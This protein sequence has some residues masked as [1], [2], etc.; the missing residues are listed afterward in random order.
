MSL[1]PSRK[2]K[3]FAAVLVLSGG[4]LFSL[5]APKP[6]QALYSTSTYQKL[7]SEVLTA[8]EWNNLF[9]DFV[10]TWLPVSL[11]GP[12]GIATPAPTSGL[13]VNGPILATGNVGIGATAPT[14]KLEIIP[15]AGSYALLAGSYRIG[16]VALPIVS[17][18]AATKG[19]VDSLLGAGS[20]P[21]A[22]LGQTLRYDGAAWISDSSLFNNATNI[23]IG[24]TAPTA[25]LE[26][27]PSAGNYALLAGNYKIG[28]VALPTVDADAATKGY[29][30]SFV[31]SSI[32]TAT[33]SIATLWGG[34]TGANIWSLN[35]GNVGIGT[36]A[37]SK[38]LEI[39]GTG[40]S[41]NLQLYDTDI[42]GAAW[43]KTQF[44]Q[45]SGVLYVK[46]V[47]ADN[48]GTGSIADFGPAS[49]IN[50]YRDV[51]I[52][53][54]VLQVT[55]TGNSYFTG[56]VGIGTTNLTA[57]LN[58][59]GDVKFEK[60]GSNLSLY[61]ANT[62]TGGG[63]FR[64]IVGQTG[65]SMAGGLG[66]YDNTAGA[67][68]LGLDSTGNLGIAKTNPAATLD[69]VGSI[70][71]TGTV[72]G[73]GLCIGGDCKV[74]WSSIG[75]AS[76][77]WSQN[78]NEV[79]KTNTAGNVG[80]G[81]TNPLVKLEVGGAIKVGTSSDTCGATNVGSV[82]YNA[83]Q[84]SM[85]YCDGTDWKEI[86]GAPLGT[87]AAFNGAC[88]SG[89]EELTEL[90]GRTIIGVGQGTGLTNRTLGETGGEETHILSID[91]MPSHSH[92]VNSN[93]SSPPPTYRNTPVGNLPA[94]SSQGNI[95]GPNTPPS[96]SL[97]GS[98]MIN[99]TG[100]ST[101]F[102]NM[103]PFIALRYCRKLTTSGGDPVPTVT[104]LSDLG[105]V[106][107]AAPVNGSTFA[108]SSSVGKWGANNNLVVDGNGNVG[109]GRTNPNA[110][111]YVSGDA[112]INSTL[113]TPSLWV[114]T[115]GTG[116]LLSLNKNGARIAGFD[117]SGNMTTN[118]T[119][120]ASGLNNSSFAGNVGIAKTSPATTVDVVG[121]INSTGT[122]NGTGLCI[123]GDCKVSWSAVG[124]AS[125]GWNRIS[126]YI[127][128]ATL[129]DNV[130]IGVTNPP[131]KLVVSQD[132]TPATNWNSAQF[133]ISGS[134]LNQKLAL[135]YDT[136]ANV[137]IIQAG[138]AGTYEP[139]AI[140]PNGGNVGIGTTA[141]NRLLSVQGV[142]GIND[143]GGV[144]RFVVSPTSGG[145]DLHIKDSAGASTVRFDTRAGGLSYVNTGNF[146]VGTASPQT[147][148]NVLG[149]T[150]GE[151]FRLSSPRSYTTGNGPMMVFSELVNG[152]QVA[153]LKGSF[154]VDGNGNYGK[155]Q[156]YTRTSD[157]LGIEEKMVINHNGNV[158]IS[159]S[160]PA[161]T[162]DVV[163]GINSTGTLNGTGLCI[164]GDCKVSWAA[165][166]AASS[167]W[168]QNGNEVYKTSISGN[169]GIGTTAPGKALEVNTDVSNGG[170][171]L[172]GANYPTFT[173]Q[174]TTNNYNV[175]IIQGD[176]DTYFEESSG[177]NSL[178]FRFNGD[179]KMTLLNSGNV[180][181]GLTNPT[182]KLEVA[183]NIKKQNKTWGSKSVQVTSSWTTVLSITMNA[184]TSATVDIN[185]GGSDWSSH[186]AQNY[187]AQ[188]V[189]RNG[190]GAYGDPGSVISE[191]NDTGTTND[192]FQSQIVNAGSGVF[193]IQIK[194]NDGGDGFAGSVSPPALPLEY[195]IDGNYTAVN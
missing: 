44:Y 15:S 107:I 9:R 17:A 146:G 14:A 29:V 78:G 135:G 115:T 43:G 56:N 144:E 113:N 192:Y 3:I 131:A 89:W 54:K 137:G 50:L 120:I 172:K 162:L 73:T 83:T 77:G 188:Y 84:N 51:T 32:A 45:D 112:V 69:V 74:S 166:G 60:T 93:I 55:G 6:A 100:S 2:L 111:L 109:V 25:K 24:T 36:T 150:S 85:Q 171:L 26:I 68:R 126:P 149:T 187:K 41:A 167:G 58:V 16:N 175:S 110:K 145:I 28:N 154:A 163:G 86:G 191:F 61:L 164:S 47:L 81:T 19:Y 105:D 57:K 180:G 189:V 147:N 155:L 117:N 170:I 62:G 63:N 12:V 169:V 21:A 104:N 75:A 106:S 116:D 139:L 18:D 101:P 11:N 118:G 142:L 52:N 148:L 130:G 161:T 99:P 97:M 102:N 33:G 141:P 82:R 70:S 114:N 79:Y 65:D 88:P 194:A 173:L 64:F 158:G 91:E 122:V 66:L 90:G 30:D 103:Q 95:Y 195:A 190:S 143:S 121:G 177:I 119:I 182:Q 160:A 59:T 37:P 10:N 181:I 39:A 128:P 157:A 34:A 35:S 138:F 108:Y 132:N 127:Y 129:T 31:A 22:T 5:G 27:I 153:G 156:F 183:G 80:I 140:N 7:Y 71:S 67:Y 4:F 185:Y 96:F 184:H 94:V 136:T 124:S 48:S 168:S 186:S 53:N 165:I 159:K 49:N 13:S 178:K 40:V 151:V 92:T 1:F 134:N 72:N 133:V 125:T 46:G 152:E 98:N 176:T 193:N 123:G 8:E 87:I 174:D 23:G 42:T 76:S 38:K 20:L 179:P